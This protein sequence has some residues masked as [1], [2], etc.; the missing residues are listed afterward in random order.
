MST[1]FSN[2]FGGGRDDKD[3]TPPKFESK[4]EPPNKDGEKKKEVNQNKS[5]QPTNVVAKPTQ[6]PQPQ[7]EPTKQQEEE[8][9]EDDMFQ[10]MEVKI[11]TKEEEDQ[12]RSNYVPP[13]T[14]TTTTSNALTNVVSSPITPQ[15]SQF[16]EEKPTS[17]ISETITKKNSSSS[18]K[19]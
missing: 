4:Y 10:D 16:Q 14:T 7:Q 15:N 11:E 8:E 19:E 6:P 1:W 13:T 2:I 17:P 12:S 9:E 18:L 5:N 3:Y